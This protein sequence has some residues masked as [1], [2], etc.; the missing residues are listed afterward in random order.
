MS[1][2]AQRL[3]TPLLL[4]ALLY[5]F[6]VCIALMGAAFKL[7]GRDFSEALITSTSTPVVGLLIGMLAKALIQSSSTTTSIIVGLV[8]AG[9]LS[10]TGAVPMIMG[11]NIGTTVT[12][13]VVALAHARQTDEFRRAFSAATMHDFFNLIAVAM[14][15]GQL[16]AAE[17][18][19][20]VRFRSA[21][22]I[23]D[24]A[25]DAI[26]NALMLKNNLSVFA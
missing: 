14:A 23:S 8:A 4:L 7:L 17:Q 18:E 19:Q 6:L 2:I 24:A 12:N 10:V 15:D 22:G 26:F 5:L 25:Y 9:A 16:R 20:I 21:L 3:R 11:A 13:T 1:T